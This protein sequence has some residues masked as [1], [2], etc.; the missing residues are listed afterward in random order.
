[1][2]N[3]LLIL[4]ILC[5]NYSDSEKN[6]RI[7]EIKNIRDE[8]YRIAAKHKIRKIYVFGSVARGENRET[9]DVD[10]IIEMEKD[11][12]ALGVG[13]FQYEVQQLLGCDIDVIPTFVFP[14]IE[15]REF[16]QHVQAEAVA[17]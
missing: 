4:A 1:M 17:I 2:R 8:L 15:D 12:S 5:D 10:F 13:G 14:R 3:K 11:A 6:M 7:E 9:S 16:V